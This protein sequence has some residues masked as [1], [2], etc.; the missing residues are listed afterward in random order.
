MGSE[1]AERECKAGM[2]DERAVGDWKAQRKNEDY[3]VYNTRKRTCGIRHMAQI[4][5]DEAMKIRTR[6]HTAK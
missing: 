6:F 4:R 3:A 2:I 5:K 1:E